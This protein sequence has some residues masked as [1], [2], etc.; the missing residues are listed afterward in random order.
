MSHRSEVWKYFTVKA[1]DNS[2]ANCITLYNASYSRGKECGAPSSFN[3]TNLRDHLMRKNPAEYR[4]LI[5]AEKKAPGD[6]KEKRSKA[7]W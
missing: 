2:R 4:T 3:T 1:T 6:K 7:V 5:V